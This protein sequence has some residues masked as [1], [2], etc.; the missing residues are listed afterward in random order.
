LGEAGRETVREFV[1]A[2]GGYLGF[3]AGAYLAAQNY[4]W[5]LRILDADVIDRQHWRR[6]VGPVEL[7]W[8]APARSRYAPPAA[9]G[10][11]KYANGPLYAAAGSDDVPDFEVLAW[12]RGEIR[13]NDAPVG[14]MRDTPAI[15][16]GRFGTGTV[17]CSSPH[18]EQTAGLVDTV[19]A[20]A[21]DAAR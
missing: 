12:F 8:T 7:E 10:D 5:S 15:V 16:R 6:G 2:G 19:R 11:V 9:R 4:D 3:C 18:P 14:V 21:R 13:N 1:R 17:I 20:L